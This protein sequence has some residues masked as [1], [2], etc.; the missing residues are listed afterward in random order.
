MSGKQRIGWE[1]ANPG[2]SLKKV[3]SGTTERILPT[4][5]TQDERL[6]NIIQATNRPFQIARSQ[7][8]DGNIVFSDSEEDE[9]VRYTKQAKRYSPNIFRRQGG[10]HRTEKNTR[11][12]KP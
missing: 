4:P 9:M 2:K 10:L 5:V 3:N 7:T 8:T 6:E 12:N 1:F 11:I